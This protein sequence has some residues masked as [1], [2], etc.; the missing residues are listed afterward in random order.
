MVASI[1]LAA[2][3]T[4]DGWADGAA[5]GAGGLGRTMTAA[6]G[7][8]TDCGVMKRGA[9]FASAGAA[10]CVLAVAASGGAGFGGTADGGVTADREAAA[11][12]GG[13]TGRGGAAG[14]AAR[15]VMAFRT[16]PGLEMCERSIFGLNSS[17][18]GATREL[19]PALG[20]CS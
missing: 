20:S 2:S 16:S 13:A 6:G 15:C 8:A 9:G 10:G 12:L 11:G 14:W 17:A 19:R 7:R 18:A 5:G 4:G 1:G 3:E